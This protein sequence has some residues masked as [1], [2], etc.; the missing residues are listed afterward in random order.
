MLSW[1]ERKESFTTPVART[2]TKAV[3]VCKWSSHRC[4]GFCFVSRKTVVVLWCWNCN[5][6][7]K[8]LAEKHVFRAPSR[9]I[10]RTGDLVHPSLD[11]NCWLP[12]G[13]SRKD[14]GSGHQLFLKGN[15]YWKD[16]CFVFLLPW[17]WEKGVLSTYILYR[18]IYCKHCPWLTHQHFGVFFPAFQNR[19]SANGTMRALEKQKIPKWPEVP[20]TCP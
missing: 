3:G 15:Y 9:K 7:F 8:S 17:L 19:R 16:P 11:R 2:K 13:T 18:F 20:S 10:F 1:E 14:H 4:P 6:R 12:C 5:C